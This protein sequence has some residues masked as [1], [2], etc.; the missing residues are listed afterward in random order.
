M[1]PPP[2]RDAPPTPAER[3]SALG[4][5]ALGPKALGPT[6]R[7]RQEQGALLRLVFALGATVA[8]GIVFFFGWAFG[9][10]NGWGWRGR[11]RWRGCWSA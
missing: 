8:S 7:D 4:P 6:P 10:G 9:P 1:P 3:P 5:K 11:G 2:D